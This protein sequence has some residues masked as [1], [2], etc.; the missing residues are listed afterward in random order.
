MRTW[1]RLILAA[2]WLTGSASLGLAK[3]HITVDLS[4]QTMHVA[5]A[6]EVF[7]WKVSTGK[8]GYETP[9]GTYGVLWMDK[10]HYSQEYDNAPMPD[11]IFFR[12]GFA[13]HGAYKSAFGHPA[14]HGCV[15]LPV[16]KAEILFDLVQAEGAEIK[17][18][19]G[20]TVAAT[21]TPSR[22][23]PAPGEDAMPDVYQNLMAQPPSG[24]AY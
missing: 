22:R 5:A 14:S 20:P 16:D 4:R 3:V 2:T 7:D 19:G 24:P 13:I 21:A 6:N 10:D 17:I 9:D 8:F 1:V 18:V 12:P 15:R 11:A 23:R